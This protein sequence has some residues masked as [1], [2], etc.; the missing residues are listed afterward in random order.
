MSPRGHTASCTRHGRGRPGLPRVRPDRL[1]I[2]P[3]R[4]RFE[5]PPAFLRED[6][7]RAA[8]PSLRTR[9]HAGS[10]DA[11]ARGSGISCASGPARIRTASRAASPSRESRQP[12]PEQTRG[13]NLRQTHDHD[14]LEQTPRT[15]CHGAAGRRDTRFS[16]V[17]IVLAP[18]LRDFCASFAARRRC[19]RNEMR[20]SC[21]LTSSRAIG[22]MHS[23]DRTFTNMRFGNATETFRRGNFA[24][25]KSSVAL[26]VRD[27]TECNSGASIVRGALETP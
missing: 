1:S 24:T 23:H 4:R 22:C 27:V 10:P 14:G 26:R 15:R 16:L 12:G 25:T 19:G 21:T 11:S 8:R 7:A 5:H 9:P 18:T 3:R 20:R 2:P 17:P 6:S 13:R